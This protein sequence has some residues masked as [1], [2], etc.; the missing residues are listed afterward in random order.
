MVAPRKV[1]ADALK[2]ALP[3]GWLIEAS[4][5]PVDNVPTTVVKLQQLAVRKLAQAPGARLEIDM[6]ATITA[7]GEDTKI[8][9]DKL[10]D[11]LL[12]FLS[13]LDELHIKW[14]ECSKV[15]AESRLGYDVTITILGMK[16]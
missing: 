8:A 6:R 16:E 14:S 10:D 1:L 13:G 15:I 12:T 2:T 9:E 7:P 4:G 3:K 11:E 5:R